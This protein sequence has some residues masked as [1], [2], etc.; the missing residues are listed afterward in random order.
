MSDGLIKD[1]NLSSSE[2]QR[3]GLAISNLIF[4][5][6]TAE[7]KFVLPN[8]ITCPHLHSSRS[9]IPGRRVPDG[10]CNS[11]LLFQLSGIGGKGEF[12]LLIISRLLQESRAAAMGKKAPTRT[13]DNVPRKTEAKGLPFWRALSWR[14]RLTLPAPSS[15]QTS[16]PDAASSPLYRQPGAISARPLPPRALWQQ[17]PKQLSQLHNWTPHPCLCTSTGFNAQVSL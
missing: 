1:Y 5:Q 13:C 3:I 11:T 9:H 8:K 15:C 14:T 16:C 17:G 4:F 6:V 12:H 2:G 10:P 7:L